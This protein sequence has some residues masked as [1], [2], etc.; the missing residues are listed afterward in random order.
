MST[1]RAFAI[2]RPISAFLA[3]TLLVSWPLLTV[4]LVTGLPPEP[5]LLVVCYVGLLGSA[6]L[7]TRWTGGPGAIRRLLSGILRWRF[8]WTRWL[9]VLTGMPLATLAVGAATGTLHAPTGPWTSVV[10][11]YLFQVVV[12]GALV[13]NVWEETAWGGFAQSL[14]MR[15]HGLLYGSLL[16]APMFAAIHLPLALGQGGGWTVVA[17]SVGALLL[18]APF[19]RY[20]L[21]MLL[22]DTGGSILAAG[23]QHASFNA[24]GN[25]GVMD[26]GWQ[27]IGGVVLLTLVVAAYRTIRKRS[28]HP[29]AA[30]PP[31]PARES[32]PA[33][34]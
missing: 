7:V 25:L 13:L 33:S 3:L 24:S 2:K 29:V 5:F 15:R 11:N 20:L 27:Q 8:G 18:T 14:L 30:F 23:L 31:S 6:L 19:I 16:T 4:P 34:E 1:L 28:G 32:I 12:L 9:L 22:L 10:L 26:G 17:V 21:G